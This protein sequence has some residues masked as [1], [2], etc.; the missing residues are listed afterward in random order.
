MVGP[1]SPG[2]AE[3]T[4]RRLLQSLAAFP[5]LAALPLLGCGRRK[6]PDVLLVIV[7]DLNDWAGCLGGHPQA[8]TPNIDRLAA[9]G[10]LFRNAHCPAPT[11]NPSRTSVL[12][13]IPATVH[14]L[15]GN[16]IPFRNRLPDAVT[17]PQHMR[18]HGYEALGCGKIFH[19]VVDEPSWSEYFA[20]TVR[21]TEPWPNNGISRGFDWGAHDLAPLETSDGQLV[22]WATKKLREAREAPLFLAVGFGRPHLP[23]FAPRDFFAPFRPEDTRLPAVREDDLAD[24]PRAA[25][26]LARLPSDSHPVILRRG[27]WHEAVAAYLACG[28]YLDWLVGELLAAFEP[29]RA[30]G[31]IVAL[32]SDHGFHLGE[33]R[34]WRKWTLWHESTRVP[35]VLAA[36]GR[37]DPG[38]TC[39][40]PVTATALGA[41]LADLCGLPPFGEVPPLTPLLDD[42]DDAGSPPAVIG[43]RRHAALCAD[44][45]RYIRYVDGSEELY[46]TRRDPSE[47]N[48]LAGIAAHAAKK[49]ELAALLPQGHDVPGGR[50][51]DHDG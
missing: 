36:P 31:A 1:G 45:W 26:Q 10:M 39:D 15:Y 7:D 5:S 12:T 9:S 13:G 29:R 25:R 20:P 22:S 24:V 6:R 14:G 21:L 33:K 17:L 49:A 28:H 43:L 32:W 37:I 35:L 38:Q 23:W 42:P 44:D 48:N 18:R 41:T 8:R 46:D 40:R 19:A 34:H 3:W 27:L 30:D 50:D 16:G 47:W 51:D 2:S 4:R 11:C